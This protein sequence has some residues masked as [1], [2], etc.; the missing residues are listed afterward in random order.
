MSGQSPPKSNVL[1]FTLGPTVGALAV[2]ASSK[3]W[4]GGPIEKWHELRL[5]QLLALKVPLDC[6]ADPRALVHFADRVA[7]TVDQ[8]TVS[9]LTPGLQSEYGKKGMSIIGHLQSLGA[10]LE[11]AEAKRLFLPSTR[12][13]RLPAHIRPT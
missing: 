11:W 5:E 1:T 4:L 8:K 3:T 10:L 2:A 9:A 12:T 7:R 6:E 13:W